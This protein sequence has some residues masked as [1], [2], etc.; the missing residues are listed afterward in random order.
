[1]AQ[2]LVDRQGFTAAAGQGQCSH[3]QPIR[4]LSQRLGA[5][6]GFGFRHRAGGFAEG[7]QR[8][9]LFLPRTVPMRCSRTASGWAK[10]SANSAYA[11]P[12]QRKGVVV[13]G[14]RVARVPAQEFPALPHAAFEQVGV[15][16][17]RWDVQAVAGADRDQVCS[18]R[19]QQ[20]S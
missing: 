8:L 13:D 10:V 3:R 7:E 12:R 20:G 4:A 9:E 19:S 17:L 2:S 1:M 15:D 18:Q 6:E 11:R 16:L 5:D 14:E